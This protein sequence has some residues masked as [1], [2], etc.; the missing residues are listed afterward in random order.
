M[1]IIPAIDI[2]DNKCVRLYQGDYNKE[3]IYD[4]D[5]VA[6]AKKWQNQGA[7]LIH[8][9][10]LDGA[11]E[12]YRKN[13][14]TILQIRNSVNC[15]LEVGGGIRSLDD[16]INLLESGIERII[17]GTIAVK[18]PF[19]VDTLAKK[20]P[21]RIILGADAKDGQVAVD[22]WLKAEN[23]DV[24]EF[25]ASFNHLDLAGVLFTD[26]ATD[27]S[28]EGPNIPAQ[29]KMGSL[30]NQPLIASGGIGS[31]NDLDSL[32]KAEINNLAGIIVGTALYEKKFTLQEA[33]E[34]VSDAC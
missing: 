12:G 19:L 13:L 26:V 30:I 11:R 29:Q 1:K 28:L 25:A 10:D 24:F 15:T 23:L 5:P 17:L 34:A 4:E 16:A 14:D 2:R 31:L 8:I 7:H 32:K 20:F 33:I 21:G 22:G 18:Q 6:R 27:G 9:V 3:K